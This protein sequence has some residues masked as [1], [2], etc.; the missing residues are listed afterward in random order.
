MDVK[1]KFRQKLKSMRLKRQGVDSFLSY[2]DKNKVPDDLI[3]PILNFKRLV[4]ELPYNEYVMKNLKNCSSEEI[5]LKVKELNE[6]IRN[7]G[8]ISVQ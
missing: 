4:N 2:L 3:E 5:E 1:N 7:L 8:C 6:T